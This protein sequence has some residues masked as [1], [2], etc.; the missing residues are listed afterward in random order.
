[1][2]AHLPEQRRL[3]TGLDLTEFVRG[4]FA[5]KEKVDLVKGNLFY[6]RGLKNKNTSKRQKRTNNKK[7]FCFVLIFFKNVINV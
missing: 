2:S 6:V 5:K 7:C 3:T 4:F 1:M